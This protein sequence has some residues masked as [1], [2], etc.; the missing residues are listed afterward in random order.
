MSAILEPLECPASDVASVPRRFGVGVLLILMTAFA[1]LF[2]MMRTFGARP[3]V[4]I[5]VSVLFLGVTLGTD[6]AVSRQAAPPGLDRGRRRGLSLGS[7][8]RDRLLSTRTVGDI[9]QRPL[10]FHRYAARRSPPAPRWVTWPAASWPV[11]SSCRR[12]SAAGRS[13]R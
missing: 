3:E 10:F 6:P 2:A 1:V 13:N 4:F 5:V 8:G 9:W 12:G 7:F 11:F